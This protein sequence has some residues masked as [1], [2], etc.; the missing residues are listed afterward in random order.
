MSRIYFHHQGP[1]PDVEVRGSE[2]AYAGHLIGEVF[3][4]I[5]LGA[6]SD[7]PNSPH[8]LRRVLKSGHYALEYAPGNPQWHRSAELALSSGMDN[9]LMVHGEEWPLFALHLNT[10]IILGGDAL[11]FLAR[12][13]GQCEIHTWV[14]GP[15]RSWLADIIAQGLEEKVL[16]N[17]LRHRYSGKEPEK[18][19]P[20]GWSEV[21]ELLRARDTGPVVLSYSVCDQ[22]PNRHLAEQ[23]GVWESQR[24]DGD[25]WYSLPDDERWN[26]AM[27]GL[28]QEVESA[29]LQINPETWAEY[30]FGNCKSAFDLIQEW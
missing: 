24:D 18:E 28:K 23:A 13:H 6:D 11:K 25:D 7:Y 12:V 17:T 16:R 27:Q 21:V 3:K 20:T 30:R 22:F 1:E 29:G 15:E 8:A 2:R 9:Y 14:D 19:S 5:V 4:A 26:L 10:A